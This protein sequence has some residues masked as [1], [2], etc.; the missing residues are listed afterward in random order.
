MTPGF[1]AA[2]VFVV[3]L[4]AAV[5]VDHWSAR[6][7]RRIAEGNVVTE[8]S[9]YRANLQNAI[10]QR[11]AL[12]QG[13][14]AYLKTH[15]DDP[16]LD[17]GFDRYSAQIAQGNPVGVRSI[18]YVVDGRIRH[19]WPRAGNEA[20]MGRDLL[21]D[22]RPEISGDLRRAMEQPGIVLS[23]PTA[24][25]QGG[26]GLIGR[27]AVPLPMGSP[28]VVA[29]VV[30]DL[31]AVLVDARLNE[32][33]G[34]DWILVDHRGERVDGSRADRSTFAGA[35][36]L[37]IRLPDREWRLVAVPIG[38]W[39]V[40]V[41][42][43][44]WPVRAT[45]GVVVALLT[46]LAWAL[47]AWQDARLDVERTETRRRADEKFQ[48]LFNLVPD[49]VVVV[50]D[51]DGMIIECNQAYAEI[52]RRPRQALVGQRMMDA[53]LWASG[54]E[55]SAALANLRSS[56]SVHDLRFGIGLPDGSRR[57]GMVTATRVTLDGEPCYLAIVRDVHDRLALE[58][59]LTEGQRLEAVG[60]LAGGIAHDFNNLVTGIGGYAAL[61]L[62]GMPTDDPGRADLIEI[63]RASG[64]AADLT[65]Q[66]LTFA[67]RQ[68]VAPRLVD[69]NVLVREAQA[70]LQRLIGDGVGLVIETASTPV[71]VMLDP[72]Q[73][74]QVLTNLAVNA[75]DAMPG[76]GMLT[77]VI[78]REDREALLDV[79]D[80]GT[81]IPSEAI[82][83]LFE[84]FYTT[85]PQGQG[86]GLGLATVYGIVQQAGGRVE[87]SSA[88]GQ[89]TTFRIRLPVS[90]DVPARAADHPVP[91]PAGHE[92]LLV[93][94][95]E[96][97]VRDLTR[98]VL[99]RLGYQ[100]QTAADGRAALALLDGGVT[101]ALILTDMVMPGMGGGEL[102]RHLAE[103][104][105]SPRVLLMSGYSEELVKSEHGDLPF[106]PKPFTPAELA[107]AV[108][109]AL[110]A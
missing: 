44:Q 96:P 106:L 21:N 51:A 100:V 3:S 94:E 74:E 67:R 89:G 57:E 64:R 99:Q 1:V 80:T 35:P 105:A 69:L 5:V 10:N 49:G 36:G 88:L 15:W 2:V 91:M 78:G 13:V 55:R 31:P 17:Q 83:H 4:A 104:S 56:G 47:T 45:L 65:R 22:P 41:T 53:G 84:P 59:R 85:K 30:L 72:T 58:R 63:Q 87:V 48:L 61:A 32:M 37:S 14:A 68:V 24:L 103:R 97:Q 108:R 110:D 52:M 20:A 25:Y 62:E 28:S 29:A 75:R 34:I 82:P 39:S 95:D 38:G 79:R 12:L 73:F 11:M 92:A 77:I 6:N 60:R 93:V 16:A 101:P 19:T 8:L 9:P 107:Q 66:L 70:F 90:D 76:G 43:Q 102:V 81:G 7:A 27:L 18:Q 109:S 54:D 86:T 40:P 50:R 46:L 33:A 98:R 71:A 23:G 42:Q 26:R